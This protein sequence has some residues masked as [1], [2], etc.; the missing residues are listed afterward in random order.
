MFSA[1][2]FAHVGMLAWGVT[3]A[4]PIIIHLWNRRTQHVI[5][6]AAMDFLLAAIHKRSRRLRL[7]QWLLLAMRAA[8]LGLLALALADPLLSD[9]SG[10]QLG[11]DPTPRQHT[12]LVID[13]SYSMAAQSGNKTVFELA[14]SQAID[15]ARL[16]EHG[17]GFTLVTLGAPPQSVVGSIAFEVEDI[18]REINALTVSHHGADLAATITEIDHLI[19]ATARSH[20]RLESC[21]VIV[22]TDLGRTTWEVASSPDLRRTIAA[23][24]EKADLAVREI[25]EPTDENVAID[26]LATPTPLA[27]F[28]RPISFEAQVLNFSLREQRRR[29]E[30]LVDGNG[31]TQQQ[32]VIPAEGSA[33]ASFSHR[34]E[35]PG[36]HLVEARIDSD[37]LNLDN[38]RWISV[39]TPTAIRVLCVEGRPLAA[40]YV[41]FALDPTS[42]GTA[43]FQLDVVSEN[44]LIDLELQQYDCL[45]LC[46]VSRL[47]DDDV[48]RLYDFVQAGGGLITILGNQVQ[49]Q[50]YN[51]QLA[52]EDSGRQLIPAMVGELVRGGPHRLEALQYQHPLIAAF[53]GHE[54]A[55]LL[56]VPIWRYFKLLP[57][58]GSQTALEFA[59]GDPALI[60][61]DIG[62]GR[63]V[64]LATSAGADSIDH[65][66]DPIVPWSALISWPSFPP[67]VHEMVNF[68]VSG[69]EARRNF[70]VGERWDVASLAESNT[71]VVVV[72]PTGQKQRTSID[73]A[74]NTRLSGVYR[75][76]HPSTEFPT[77]LVAV[78]L[79]THE[80]DLERLPSDDLPSQFGRGAANLDDSSG[81]VAN[82]H[83]SQL[84]RLVLGAVFLLV[85][86]ESTF[87]WWLSTRSS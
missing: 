81:L 47:G 82:D 4:I 74:Q 73:A 31:V 25:G 41:A 21:R 32:L 24:A 10:L 37:G 66:S 13:N 12:V 20:P 39:T 87:A 63:S 42:D 8:I 19:D 60:S 29:I 7:E 62:R 15:V 70:L 68:S 17:D 36:Q 6:W 16:S 59:G 85:L 18:V 69:R 40:R 53:R 77:E 34:F 45:I 5:R 55:G 52:G 26:R 38:H 3:I 51:E 76:E 61:Q 43:D 72:D 48:T 9:F 67:L 35:M 86:A 44:A 57:R 83:P 23:L 22:F 64:L 56:T 49:P 11:F 50:N 2:S 84:F 28:H 30:F 58:T 71:E 78:N 80:G 65:T 54:R 33:T 46:N 27:P 1:W 79:D 75:I 14:K